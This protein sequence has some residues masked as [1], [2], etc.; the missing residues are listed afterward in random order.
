MVC[1]IRVE[2]PGLLTTIQDQGRR[3]Y[4]PSALSRGGAQDA[5]ALATANLLVGNDES[6]AGLEI[7]GLG[8][9]LFL[10]IRPVSPVAVRL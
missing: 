2:Q 3:N 7:T 1:A 4:L 8:P 5:A 6:A 9:T 10:S